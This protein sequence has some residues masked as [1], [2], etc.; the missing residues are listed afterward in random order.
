MTYKKSAKIIYESGE[1]VVI[2]FICRM[3]EKLRSSQKTIAKLERKIHVLESRLSKNSRNSHKPPAS[4]GL[5]RPNP[6]SLRKKTVK[7]SGGQKGYKGHT[8]KMV[9]NPDH[10][11]VYAVERCDNCG[12]SLKDETP[13]GIE[14]RQV[15]D[16]P[17]IKLEVTE[18][19]AEVKDCPHCEQQTK[20]PFPEEVKAPVQYG[21]R[22]KAITVYLKA[23]QLIPY[24]RT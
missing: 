2:D 24:K 18:H 17:P 22:L 3:S 4:E 21:Q 23:Y 10:V 8:L 20:A 7:K 5:L 19:Q 15:F 9:D 16:I 11:M 13:C 14:K 6:K 1:S 12:C